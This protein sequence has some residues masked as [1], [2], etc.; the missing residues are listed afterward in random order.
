MPTGWKEELEELG[1]EWQKRYLVDEGSSGDLLLILA[2]S[3]AE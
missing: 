3:L 1:V 2:L